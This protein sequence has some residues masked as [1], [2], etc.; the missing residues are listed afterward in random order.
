M[1]IVP[2]RQNVKR[3]NRP[4]LLIR[5]GRQTRFGR[6]IWGPEAVEGRDP[7]W[8]DIG[9]RSLMKLTAIAASAIAFIACL[10]IGAFLAGVPESGARGAG[11]LLVISAV[12]AFAAA[13][14]VVLAPRRRT[15]GAGRMVVVLAAFLA[16]LPMV[17]ISGVALSFSGNPLGS[18]SPYLDWAS[19]AVG[20]LL[21]LGAVSIAALA[22]L[23]GRA[24]PQSGAA[25]DVV[26][27]GSGPGESAAIVSGD[28]LPVRKAGS[29]AG[30]GPRS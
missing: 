5:G 21:A 9:L 26:V 7:F 4:G 23:P 16:L 19:F 24:P 3:G 30:G 15:R 17:A 11:V 29:G 2:L 25:S 20:I 8:K 22:V 6:E 1:G 28:D 12:L 14:F 13:L 18:A 27:Q 10:S